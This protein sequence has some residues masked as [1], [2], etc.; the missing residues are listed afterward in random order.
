V[1]P[2]VSEKAE[3]S[4]AEEGQEGSRRSLITGGGQASSSLPSLSLESRVVFPLWISQ[5]WKNLSYYQ[6]DWSKALSGIQTKQTLGPPYPLLSQQPS[7]SPDVQRTLILRGGSLNLRV[8]GS[9][10]RT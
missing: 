1:F 3:R 4:I 9:Y 5:K 2:G 8:A 10:T 7:P 6:R